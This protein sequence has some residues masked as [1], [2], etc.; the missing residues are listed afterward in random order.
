MKVIIGKLH[1]I[2]VHILKSK[3]SLLI[4]VYD[5]LFEE[6]SPPFYIKLPILRSL[7]AIM[8][9][10]IGP[11]LGSNLFLFVGDD[12]VSSRRDSKTVDAGMKLGN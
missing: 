1:S 8:S 5:P 2:K 11:L 7:E 6:A 9:I 3:S 10:S 4:I 12:L